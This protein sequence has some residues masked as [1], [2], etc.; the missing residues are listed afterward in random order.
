MCEAI[1]H[2]SSVPI[3]SSIDRFNTQIHPFLEVTFVMSNST[4]D[5]KINAFVKA[6]AAALQRITGKP[7]KADA[8][9][10][11]QSQEHRKDSPSKQTRVG[12]QS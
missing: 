8:T 1:I 3:I 5:E 4:E 12:R 9:D 6:L 10:W 2:D 11:P 7:L